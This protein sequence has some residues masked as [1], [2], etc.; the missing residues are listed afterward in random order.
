MMMVFAVM[1]E[2]EVGEVFRIWFFKDVWGIRVIYGGK[3]WGCEF[4]FGYY[5]LFFV[6]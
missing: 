6:F 4:I 5:G 3:G 2:V 1:V